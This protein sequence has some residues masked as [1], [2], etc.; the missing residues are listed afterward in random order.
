MSLKTEI[1]HRDADHFTVIILDNEVT[2]DAFVKTPPL[3]WTRLI[4][5]EFGYIASEKYPTL[6]TKEESDREEI[7]WDK[8]DLDRIQLEIGE[9]DIFD[10]LIAIGNNAAQGLPLAKALPTSLRENNSIIIYGTSL[11]E[12]PEYEALGFDKFC[13]R[14]DLLSYLDQ[15][16][17]SPEKKIALTFINTIQHN[18][19]NYH[20]P[21]VGR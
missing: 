10:G 3:I 16:Q 12:K 11:P 14:A 18:K 8:V 21:W 7:N 4:R 5:T 20:Q 17:L 9:L 19:L 13:C 15:L 2:L 6:L 1:A